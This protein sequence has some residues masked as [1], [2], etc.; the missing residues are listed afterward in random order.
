MFLT[1][2]IL[3]YP[4]TAIAA[5]LKES[6]YL[7]KNSVFEIVAH[8]L[9]IHRTDIKSELKLKKVI[10]KSNILFEL[11]VREQYIIK[12][13]SIYGQIINYATKAQSQLNLTERQNR[14]IS[15]IK[16]ANRKMV[17]II[18]DVSELSRN[19]TLYLNS[20]NKYIKKEYDKLRKR[21]AKV[22]RTIHLFRT[23]KEKE[24]YHKTLMKLKTEAK[25]NIHKDNLDIDLLIRKDLI[26]VDMA[27]SLVNDNDNVNDM[28]KKLINVD[29]LLYGK[30]DT[31]LDNDNKKTP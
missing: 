4:E 17:E 8:A 31:L 28:I 29:E 19:I 26:T 30:G 22:L 15:D 1:N 14:Q 3:E 12:I 16:V 10:Q 21:V 18:R 24:V 7:Y 20:E 25:E 9:N 13:K 23:E 6:K 11:N 2:A 5:L 27:S